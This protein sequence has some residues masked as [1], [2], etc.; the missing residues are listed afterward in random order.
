MMSHRLFAV[1]LLAV[2]LPGA[3]GQSA[4][5]AT[6]ELIERLLN[7]IDGLEKRVQELEK[8]G[9]TA[10]ATNRPTAV[11]VSPPAPSPTQAPS[12]TPT[13][14][15]HMSHDQPP[16]PVVQSE[17][18]QPVYP[19]LKI[20]GFGDVNFS[21]TDFHGTSSGFAPQ[22][23]VLPHSGFEEGQLT[24]HL[25]SALSPKVTV[26]SEITLTSRADAG[27]GTPP[28]TGFNAEV[29]RFIIRY[30]LNDYF[31]LSFGRYHTPIN[32]WNTAFH[33]GQWLQTTISRPEMTQFGGSFI[34][35]H[36]VGTLVEGAVPASGLNL[37]YNFGLG[38]GRGAVISRPG[39]FGDVNNNRAW[40]GNFFVKP[41][42][43]YGLQVGGS[44]YRDELN[45]LISPAAREW[46][47]SAH[48]VWQKETP[49]FIAEF[50]NVTHE[51]IKGGVTSNSQAFYVQT[52]YRLPFGQKLWK[53]YFRFESIHVPKSDPIFTPLVPT[54]SGSTIGL[55]YD[56]S[57]FAAFKWEYRHYDLRSRPA[58]NGVFVQT[59]FTF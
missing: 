28:A 59:S 14:A 46:I 27:T 31:K 19:S 34:P 26:F 6:R 8:G 11:P 20:A 33:H 7:R 36:F 24:L 32:Y 57:S 39:D 17:A 22:T 3:R 1:G 10:L 52:A 30:D 47:Q 5:P 48:I 54:F 45:P 40:L 44:V 49:E 42:K 21:A 55:R 2:L 58:I 16:V 18:T 53:P 25:S 41:D 9:A 56:I 37:N 23:L 13:E 15:M 35:V 38:N 4:D 51:P 43:L 12:L 50:A 29:E